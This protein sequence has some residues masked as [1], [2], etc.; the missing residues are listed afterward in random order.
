MNP[1]PL[2]RVLVIDEGISGRQLLSAPNAAVKTVVVGV[3]DYV[4]VD[5]AL[6]YDHRDRAPVAA[7]G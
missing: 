3:V 1:T 5:G 2:I 4:E 6:L 7:R